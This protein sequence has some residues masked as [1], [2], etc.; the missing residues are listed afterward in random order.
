MT[1]RH[2]A[3]EAALK[4]LYSCEISGAPAN[5]AISSFFSEHWPDADMA[6]RAFS[7]EL[8][9]GA[10]TDVPAIDALI[11]QH[12]QH[13]RLERL[14]ILDRLILRIAVWELQHEPDLPAAV[15]LNEALELARTYSTDGSVAFVN[16]VL[17]GIRN[18]LRGP[19]SQASGLSD[20]R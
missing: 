17:D 4:I 6:V 20:E 16:G 13:W 10:L 12:S 14:A 5:E 8:V 11:A 3:R 9:L 15:V 18:T 7:S 2:D 19:R 1:A